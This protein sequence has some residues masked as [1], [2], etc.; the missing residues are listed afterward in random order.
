M[1][2]KRWGRP[3]VEEAAVGGQKPGWQRRAGASSVQGWPLPPAHASPEAT[4]MGSPALLTHKMTHPLPHHHA[5]VGSRTP[6]CPLCTPC[7]GCSPPRRACR[8]LQ[9]SRRGDSGGDEMLTQRTRT[10]SGHKHGRAAHGPLRVGTSRHGPQRS[11]AMAK[12]WPGRMMTSTL[13]SGRRMP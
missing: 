4:S 8:H 9:A 11:T 5:P 3:V 13:P 10:P 1:S 7:S 12:R 6:G 2:A